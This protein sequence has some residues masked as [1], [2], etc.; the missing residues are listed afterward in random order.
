M[1]PSTALS[2]GSGRKVPPAC[3]CAK[4]RLP[5]QS[6][7]LGAFIGLGLVEIVSKAK[8]IGFIGDGLQRFGLLS[9]L[10]LDRLV[11]S[12]NNDGGG[13]D[14]GHGCSLGWPPGYDPRAD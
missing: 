3:V 8:M 6:G 10:L 4:G 9:D 14:V 7:R 11:L 1:R 12:V 5:G 13:L 2:K